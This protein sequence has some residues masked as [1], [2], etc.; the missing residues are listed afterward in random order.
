MD[1]EVICAKN[2]VFGGKKGRDNVLARHNDQGNSVLSFNLLNPLLRLPFSFLPNVTWSYKIEDAQI[3]ELL[4]RF[5][6]VSLVLAQ[7]RCKRTG[8]ASAAIIPEIHSGCVSV[9]AEV[10]LFFVR[11]QLVALLCCQNH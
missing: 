1:V 6:N 8:G 5:L 3:L 9:E 10:S 4:S 7:P 11:N 2:G